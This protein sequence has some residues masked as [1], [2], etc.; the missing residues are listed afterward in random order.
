MKIKGLFIIT[1]VALCTAIFLG[2]RSTQTTN[3][4]QVK[5]KQLQELQ[6]KVTFLDNKLKKSQ[7]ELSKS[8]ETV[9]KLTAEKNELLQK[10]TEKIAV[11][12]KK[13][14]ST[15]KEQIPVI[16]STENSE[17]ID[18][19]SITEEEVEESY[20]NARLTETPAVTESPANDNEPNWA[21]QFSNPNLTGAD[22]AKLGKAKGDYYRNKYG[23]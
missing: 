18:Q 9:G 1:S 13:D 15:E 11:E 5:T 3:L 19:Q 21:E 4:L 17:E 14:D 16:N 10:K 23:H 2:I 22:R 6:D 20:V 7:E 8:K 12:T